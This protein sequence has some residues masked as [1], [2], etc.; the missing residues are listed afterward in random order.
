MPSNEKSGEMAEQLDPPS[1]KYALSYV[2]LYLPVF[3]R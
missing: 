1:Q 3:D 2:S